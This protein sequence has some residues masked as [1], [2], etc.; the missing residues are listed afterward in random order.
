MKNCSF[1]L[2]VVAMMCMCNCHEDTTCHMSNYCVFQ[3]LLSL[4]N[5]FPLTFIWAVRALLSLVQA[6]MLYLFPK[7]HKKNYDFC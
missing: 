1:Y 5:T 7:W 2:C 4:I 6:Y 3:I